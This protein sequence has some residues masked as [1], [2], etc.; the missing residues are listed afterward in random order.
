M[1]RFATR[2]ALPDT[3]S[4]APLVSRSSRSRLHPGRAAGRDTLADRG[5]SS[6]DMDIH[7][8]SATPNNNDTEQVIHYIIYIHTYT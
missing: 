5:A 6:I 7:N 4:G 3:M 2:D 1:S 8:N